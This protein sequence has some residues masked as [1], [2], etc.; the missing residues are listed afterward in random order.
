MQKETLTAD[1]PPPPYRV[2]AEWT[3]ANGHVLGEVI[4][5]GRNRLAL[6][7]YAV[8]PS[9]LLPA[10]YVAEVTGFTIVR[11]TICGELRAWHNVV[12]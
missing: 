11:C 3:C 9:G 7:P 4:H 5:R 10:Y 1:C 8:A 12:K 2:I 6:Y